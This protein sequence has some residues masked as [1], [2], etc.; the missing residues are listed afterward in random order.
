MKL[1]VIAVGYPSLPRLAG[2]ADYLHGDVY[3]NTVK[4]F[5]IRI[6]YSSAMQAKQAQAWEWGIVIVA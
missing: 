4:T 6:C 3:E 1:L 2:P 5:I